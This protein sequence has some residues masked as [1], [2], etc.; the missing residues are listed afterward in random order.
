MEEA[1]RT[2]QIKKGEIDILELKPH[3]RN[4][5]F[6]DDMVDEKWQEFLESVKTS[7][8]IEPIIITQNNV[9]VSGHQ[10][11]RA[12]KE[13]GLSEIKFEKR[14]YADEDHILKDLLETNLRQRGEIGGSGIKQSRRFNEL[15]R[16]Y[17][18][19]QGNNQH[20]ANGTNLTQEQLAEQQGVD[21]TTYKR[22]KSLSSLPQEIQDMVE[23]GNIT[24]S[25][26]SRIIAK[27]SKEDREELSKSLSVDQKYAQKDIQKLVDEIEKKNADIEANEQRIRELESA[28]E[29]QN[30]EIQIV[31]HT[32]YKRITELEYENEQLKDA[33]LTVLA[34]REKLEEDYRIKVNENID[35]R[36]RV[37]NLVEQIPP[38]PI[39][40][41]LKKDA[42]FFCSRCDTFIKAVGGYA[43]IA[44]RID[45]LP[46]P[47]R[48]M[49]AKS[50]SAMCA[51]SQNIANVIFKEE[52]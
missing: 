44:D 2:E 12:C 30:P 33:A 45:A 21:L 17:G 34:D 31:D 14:F 4:T 40:D 36:A 26:A 38:K 16:L 19:K 37:D 11:V 13:L 3:P 46:E 39:D 29:N 1:K 48:T 15:E 22:I 28:L 5:E 32:D 27:L 51:W 7:G 8:I 42:I 52:E 20:S 25:A 18:I 10:R 9:I 35:L 41:Q 49:Y 47:E 43:Y 23:T 50:I 24:V 6:F